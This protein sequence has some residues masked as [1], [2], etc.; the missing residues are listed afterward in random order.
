MDKTNIK[1]V[2]VLATGYNLVDIDA[3]KEKEITVTNIPT[4]GTNAVAQMV[5]AHILQICHHLSEHDAAVK[6]GDWTNNIDWC[7]GTI[8]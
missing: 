1:Y 7:F 6:K 2:G 8:H 3:A 4:Y 5:F